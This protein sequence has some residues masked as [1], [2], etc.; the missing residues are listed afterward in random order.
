MSRR[1]SYVEKPVVD[2]VMEVELASWKY[3]HDYIRKE[4]LQHAHYFWRGQRDASWGLETSLDRLISN[5]PVNTQRTLTNQQLANFKMS[6]RGRRGANPAK[7]MT[8]NDWW[9]LG[10]HHSLATPLLDW[11]HAP[12]VALYFA[13]EKESAPESGNRAV[14]A[15][16]PDVL[17]RDIKNKDP[18]DKTP[19]ILEVI[20]PHQDENARLVSQNGLFT[21]APIGETALTWVQSK[22]AGFTKATLLKI[23]IPDTDRENCLRSLNRM[24]I[25]HLTLFP[26]LYGSGQHS[27]KLLSIAKY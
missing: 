5:K 1:K 14:W 9:A 7:D 15:M 2:G 22:S 10:Q 13:F 11:T 16:Y 12:F 8:D 20:R 23:S 27:N 24:N 17:N 4:V 19:P 6:S 18:A 25:N 26:D 21:K 3:F